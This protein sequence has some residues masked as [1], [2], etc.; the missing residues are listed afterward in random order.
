MK[1][2]VAVETQE[3]SAMKYA[4]WNALSGMIHGHRLR[5]QEL[6]D[7]QEEVQGGHKEVAGVTL[8][9][10]LVTPQ[11]NVGGGVKFARNLGILPTFAGKIL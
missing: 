8:V 2:L 5:R 6:E 11:R 3:N 4:V 9:S 7:H 10:P 1:A